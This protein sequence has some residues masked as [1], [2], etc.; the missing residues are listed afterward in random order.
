MKQFEI[1]CCIF[2]A[3]STGKVVINTGICQDVCS[4][5]VL[6]QEHGWNLPNDYPFC[7]NFN[8]KLTD[9]KKHPHKFAK[10]LTFLHSKVLVPADFRLS[11]AFPTHFSLENPPARFWPSG[12]QGFMNAA[13]VTTSRWPCAFDPSMWGQVCSTDSQ[14]RKWQKLTAGTPKNGGLG[15]KILLFLFKRGGDFLGFM[16]IFQGVFGLGMEKSQNNC[17]KHHFVRE[18]G[19]VL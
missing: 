13:W 7:P 12:P 8:G 6:L 17:W 9:N 10:N 16:L 3:R 4:F 15:W 14:W 18:M 19:R 2:Q 5:S 1:W 11:V